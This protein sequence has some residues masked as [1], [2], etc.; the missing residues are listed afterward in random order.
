MENYSNKYISDKSISEIISIIKPKFE[1]DG[2][3]IIQDLDI[4][5]LLN[6]K[7]DANFEEYKTIGICNPKLSHELLSQDKSIGL[8]LP[9]KIAFYQDNGKT[10]IEFQRPTWISKYFYSKHIESVTAK[11]EEI[12]DTVI[13]E[14]I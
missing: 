11:V 14:A 9:C 3:G 1:S 7:V 5:K 10:K 8:F 13:K 4:G 6:E 12:M 2:F